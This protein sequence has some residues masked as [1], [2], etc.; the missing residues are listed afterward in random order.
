MS[1]FNRLISLISLL[2][3][4]MSSHAVQLGSAK[5]S[6]IFGRPL[7]VTV[8]VRL[9]STVEDAANCFSAEVF[10]ADNKFDVGRI[11]LD[12]S[13]ATNGLDATLRIR[14]ASVVH[15]PWAKIIL[16]SNCG[17]KVTKQYDFLTDFVT[18][19]PA[20]AVQAENKSAP[21][22]PV[23]ITSTLPP[24]TNTSTATSNDI[25][26]SRNEQVQ[27][28]NSTKSDASKEKREKRKLKAQLQQKQLQANDPSTLVGQKTWRT[29]QLTSVTPQTTDASKTAKTTDAADTALGQPRLK[30]ETFVLTDEHQIMLRLTKDLIAPTGMRTPQEIEALAQATAVWRAINSNSSTAATVGTDNAIAKAT[31]ATAPVPAIELTPSNL[32]SLMDQKLAG[33][34]EFSNV[35]V[36]GLI[37][38][39]AIA[40]GC[41]TWLW[42]R[43]RKAT[44]AGYDWLN[45]SAPEADEASAP[46]FPS[47]FQESTFTVAN[48]QT[49]KREEPTL[50]KTHTE[51]EVA[52]ITE[53]AEVVKVEEVPTEKFVEKVKLAVVPPKVVPPIE[54]VVSQPD[55]VI[56]DANRIR[57]EQ[58]VHFEDPR[59]EDLDFKLEQKPH[60]ETHNKPIA[61]SAE[62]MNLVIAQTPPKRRPA[63]VA[64]H[65]IDVDISGLSLAPTPV[66]KPAAVNAAGKEDAKS[67]LINFD[68]FADPAQV[69]KPS[70]FAR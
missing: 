9:E 48:F 43:M 12:I 3:F 44:Q 42:I 23:I 18:D 37:G 57:P 4:A 11:K 69:D 22:L 61:S 20:S 10:Q 52:E 63:T 70:R 40:L 21:A 7:D 56:M 62:L 15:E 28:A 65:P 2:A 34:N 39:L 35:I 59:F 60:A 49:V 66:N 68:I 13:P 30:M 26:A 58:P 29:S 33:K 45:G 47:N 27:I 38:L 8:Q 46:F 41:I 55:I 17:S 51:K 32:P 16:R 53:V 19:M 5:G 25:N 54:M 1:H 50:E 14:S 24:A 31:T 6:A 67:N 64:T 36:Y